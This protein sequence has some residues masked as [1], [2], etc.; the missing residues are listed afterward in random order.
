MSNRVVQCCWF[1]IA[2]VVVR[3]PEE[4]LVPIEVPD[5]ECGPPPIDALHFDPFPNNVLSEWLP[6]IVV[7]ADEHTS[8]PGAR[9]CPIRRFVE[10]QL[11]SQEADLTHEGPAFLL[12]IPI[13]R[14]A[15]SVQIELQRTLGIS[16]EEDTSR[17]EIVH[18][19][20]RTTRV[21]KDSARH[22]QR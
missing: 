13:D 11:E 8:L 3:E 16:H 9:L 17:V 18:D 2:E 1:E 4:N 10:D 15:E 7:E 22:R 14:E 21:G 12:I 20:L 6:L 19:R 5:H